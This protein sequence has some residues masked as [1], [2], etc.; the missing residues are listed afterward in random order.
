[1]FAVKH[2]YFTANIPEPNT[3]LK[4]NTQ[5]LCPEIDP[6]SNELTDEIKNLRL[7]TSILPEIYDIEIKP[8]MT[9]IDSPNFDG[10]VVM[11]ARVVKNT[12]SIIFHQLDLDIKSIRLEVNQNLV[13]RLEEK[14]FSCNSYFPNDFII[15]NLD[16]G[17]ELEVGDK[18]VIFVSYSGILIDR[19]KGIY[20]TTYTKPDG[21]QQ[22]VITSIGSPTSTRRTFPHFDEPAMKAE[23]IISIWYPTGNTEDDDEFFAL[24]NMP[25]LQTRISKEDPFYSIAT[26]QKTPKMSSYLATFIVCDFTYI[27]DT[28]QSGIPIRV[29]LTKHQNELNRGEWALNI[30]KHSFDFYEQDLFKIPYSLPKIDMIA[31]PN[32]AESG[33][34]E[35][36]GI[37]TY[38]ESNL[39]L[40]DDYESVSSVY[41]KSW[42]ANIIAHELSHMWFGNLVTMSWWD[43]AWLNEGFATYLSY[44]GVDASIKRIYGPKEQA[45]WDQITSIT[46]MIVFSLGFDDQE[47]GKPIIYAPTTNNEITLPAVF[48]E[49]IYCKG[50]SFV[51]S[52]VEVM[53]FDEFFKAV[54]GYLRE[55]SFGNVDSDDLLMALQKGLGESKLNATDSSEI[56]NFGKY[57]KN[58]LNQPGYPLIKIS[59][60][61]N[62]RND[63][64]SSFTVSQTQFFETTSL[65]KKNTENR[66]WTIPIFD[67]WMTEENN[68]LTV[69][70]RPP[71][72]TIFSKNMRIFA[73]WQ[74]PKERNEAIIA[75]L[76]DDLDQYSQVDRT[77]YVDDLFALTFSGNYQGYSLI[78]K[79]YEYLRN[80]RS[81]FV[82]TRV[83]IHTETLIDSLEK[84]NPKKLSAFADFILPYINPMADRLEFYD[85]IGE[86]PIL[87]KLLRIRFVDFLE[88]L[89]SIKLQDAQWN[90]SRK[91]RRRS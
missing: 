11:Q 77:Q 65:A 89:E 4:P 21:S 17:K 86:L 9:K 46:D 5:A 8:N 34:M 60:Q 7:P 14:D 45:S 78:I 22:Q 56:E 57:F 75:S 3:Y 52:L 68:I 88:K 55:N 28:S 41:A 27:E 42:V 35:N 39:L 16:H 79:M 36:W 30:S 50:A 90:V 80:E 48:N 20:K 76:I 31:I 59:E 85:S 25:L 29:Y 18:I 51:W 6:K 70:P 23:H 66:F 43:D 12:K 91:S 61:N 62:D 67:Q 82:W 2:A 54:I 49:F 63:R 24:S 47:T 10:N 64:N 44:L 58:Y 73:R 1:M 72:N 15:L 19:T 26:F 32:H 53:G 83:I 87:E 13:Y 74:Y 40:Y 69:Y 81:T 33:A 84:S 38:K 71:L 37:V